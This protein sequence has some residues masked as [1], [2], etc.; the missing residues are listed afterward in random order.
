MKR[1]LLLLVVLALAGVGAWWFEQ[2][3]WAQPGPAQSYKVVMVE[4]GDH[5][6]VIA[7]HLAEA[8]VISNAD[9]FRLGLRIRNLQGTLKAGE[10]GFPAHL[11][12]A[13]VAGI[14]AS[15]KSIQHKLTAAEG[16]TSKMIYDLVV[17]DKV[18]VGD[19]GA[20]PDEGTLLPET[21]LF[22]R[23]TTRAELLKR[24]AKARDKLLDKL[25]ATR[26]G[27]LPLKS[28]A[29]AITLASIVEK[30]TAIPE[31]RR[32]VASVFVNRLKLGMKL[33]SDPTIIYDVTGGYPLG[34]GIR[35]SELKRASPHN[36]YAIP[37]LPPTPICNPGRDA[38]AA[39]LDPATSNDLY[40]VANGTG[41]HAFSATDAEQ[42]R[43]VAAWR[44]IEQQQKHVDPLPLPQL[45]K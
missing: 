37:G 34:R 18:L 31:E 19:A 27:A 7:Q 36:T 4:P 44:K 3:S 9:L 45:R 1:F 40:F 39:V 16:L 20:V 6:A 25:W 5:V 43:N 35:E 15:G 38:I 2:W 26:A 13:D 23:G 12:M 10:Y 22:T 28:R 21:Y 42:N 33:Q 24:M 41:G 30:E 14:V 8:G 17:A 29:E 11:S 32:H